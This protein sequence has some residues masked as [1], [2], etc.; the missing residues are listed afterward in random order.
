[1]SLLR[2][3][4]KRLVISTGLLFVASII[5]FMIIH[6]LPGD[7]AKIIL[8]NMATDKSVAS[9]RREL[10]LH[11]PLWKQYVN[12]V[13]GI[14]S[15][16][17]GESLI[18]DKSVLVLMETRY[19]RSLQI[20]VTSMAI[21]LVIAFP[22]GV[23]A[24]LNRNSIVD[25]VAVVFSQ[26][27]VSLPSFWLG[28]ILILVFAK[29]LDVL[30][31]SGY[32]PLGEG[33]VTSMLHTVL[34]AVALGLINAAIFTRYLRSEL[35]EEF[36]KDYVRTA[37]AFGHPRRRIVWKYVLRN[38]VIPT[39]TIMGIQFGYMIGGIVIIEQ[40]FVYPGIGQLILDGLLKRDYPVVQMGLLLLAATFILTNL[41]VDVLYGVLDPRARV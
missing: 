22:L 13:S 4:G 18:N 14:L 32:V 34:P 11:L 19:P 27:G 40:V 28:I 39:L 9:L 36:N 10:G 41:V 7:P 24:A 1:M 8:G 30:P 29:W 20:A 35:L 16:N 15:G 23:L 2:Y 37:R 6:L 38:A 3:I 33:P 31:P 5:V 17:W 21:S 26:L 25:Y 12:W